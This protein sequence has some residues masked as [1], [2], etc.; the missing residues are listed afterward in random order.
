MTKVNRFES[1]K[2]DV[3]VEKAGVKYKVLDLGGSTIEIRVKSDKELAKDY[4]AFAKYLSG[5][6]GCKPL[7]K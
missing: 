6:D 2:G 1:S 3:F 4:K 5:A 7:P